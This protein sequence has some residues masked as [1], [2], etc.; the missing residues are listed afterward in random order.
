MKELTDLIHMDFYNDKGTPVVCKT[1]GEVIEQ[2][3]RLP[4]D[5][6]IGQGFGSAVRL[7]VYNITREDPHL[8]FSEID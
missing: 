2:L 7:T 6:A 3:K 4:D 5:L 8:D 1:V